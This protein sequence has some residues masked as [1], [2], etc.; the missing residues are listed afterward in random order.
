MSA[1]SSPTMAITI[2]R[3]L[4]SQMAA[5][6]L[7]YRDLCQLLKQYGV[8]QTE[9]TLRSKVNTGTLGAQLFLYLQLAMGIRAVSTEQIREILG[10]AEN[11]VSVWNV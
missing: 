4:R 10:D 11:E 9:S 8:E 1:Y 7:E 5:K 6:G 3:L 2:K